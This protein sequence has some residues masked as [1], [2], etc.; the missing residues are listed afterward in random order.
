MVDTSRIHWRIAGGVFLLIALAIGC[1]PFA[2]PFYLLNLNKPKLPSHYSFY[3]KA[4]EAKGKKEIRVAVLVER[5][6]GL[7]PDFLGAERSL[8]NLLINGLRAGFEVN[9][10]R[11][12]VLPAAVI[13][14]FKR[15]NENWRSLEGPQIA[16][17]L[18]VDY[19]FDIELASMSL[20]EP[21]SRHLFRGN[22][23]VS[24]RVIDA[25]ENAPEIFPP[26]EYVKEFPGNGVTVAADSQTTAQQ[27]QNQ[28]LAKIALDLTGL[29]TATHTRD[30]FQ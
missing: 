14:D 8:A 25:D 23:V 3:E 4:R 16:R 11:V 2:L 21:G 29:F 28:F 18:D 20:Y 1:K 27:F 6:R 7:S 17:K 30:R 22:C 5:G 26:Y 12:T 13:D 10:E 9:K 24:V 15:K 19:V